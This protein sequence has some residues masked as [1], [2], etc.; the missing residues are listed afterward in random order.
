[1][2][3]NKSFTIGVCMVFGAVAVLLITMW[4]VVGDVMP[5]KSI[6]A[7]P[8]TASAVGCLGNLFLVITLLRVAEGKD[9]QKGGA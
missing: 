7:V 1:M 9:P 5:L 3:T 4:L 2:S 6:W 8:A